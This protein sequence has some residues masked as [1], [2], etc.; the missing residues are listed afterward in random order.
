MQETGIV[1]YCDILGYRTFLAENES[2]TPAVE[3]V[4]RLLESASVESRAKTI[5]TISS[6]KEFAFLSEERQSRVFADTIILTMPLRKEEDQTRHAVR[7]VYLLTEAMVLHHHMFRRGLPVR[8]AV[9]VGTYYLTETCFAGKCIAEAHDE[10]NDIQLSAVSITPKAFTAFLEAAK[11]GEDAPLYGWLQRI[12]RSYPTPCRSGVGDKRLLHIPSDVLGIPLEEE[13]CA[14]AAILRAFSQ[15]RKC[16]D[17]DAERKAR[18]T[19][20]YMRFLTK[21]H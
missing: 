12:V 5:E 21:V 10:V 7:W 15:H 16:L 2:I 18:N 14:M 3:D 20:D 4:I 11:M 9:T 6:L 1:L 19:F 8:C 17:V 13:G